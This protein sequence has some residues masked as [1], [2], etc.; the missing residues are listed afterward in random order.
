MIKNEGQQEVKSE[1]KT[2]I[3]RER[4]DDDTDEDD[5]QITMS[6]SVRFKSAG[7]KDETIKLESARED[8]SRV[9]KKST[10]SKHEVERNNTIKSEGDVESRRPSN[11]SKPTIRPQPGS[12]ETI[13]LCGDD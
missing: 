10:N 1:P 5:V 4:D 2:G 13:D 8:E 12:A 6:R 7:S 3:K 9:A 11:R